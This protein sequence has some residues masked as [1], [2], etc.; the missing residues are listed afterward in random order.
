MTEISIIL[1]LLTVI[2]G[3]GLFILSGINKKVSD[4][5]QENRKEHDE[6]F[7]ARRE[8]EKDIE[9]INQLHHLKGCDLP[10]SHKYQHEQL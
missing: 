9:T 5:C 4:I 8:I 3:L 2:N 1:F 10:I 7:T 6:L